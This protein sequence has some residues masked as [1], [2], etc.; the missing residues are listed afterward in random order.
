MLFAKVFF[1]AR[2]RCI[3]FSLRAAIRGEDAAEE[4]NG[5]VLA[6]A[7]NIFCEIRA[8]TVW[9]VPVDDGGVIVLGVYHVLRA[10]DRVNNH[11]VQCRVGSVALYI[12]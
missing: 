4:Q 7:P 8:E 12:H 3:V 1:Q 2:G 10:V 9:Q 5:H 6:S 11:K